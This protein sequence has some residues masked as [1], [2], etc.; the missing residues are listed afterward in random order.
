LS[1]CPSD[2]DSEV[3]SVLILAFLNVVA[4]KQICPQVCQSGDKG[5]KSFER[6]N[7]KNFCL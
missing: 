3:N 5:K 6:E 7:L 2:T 4:S 1:G